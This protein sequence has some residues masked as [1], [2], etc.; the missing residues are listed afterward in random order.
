MSMALSSPSTEVD[1]FFSY[2]HSDERLRD[3]LAKHL[4]LLERQHFIRSWHDRRIGAGDE[5]SHAIDE[6]LHG[7]GIILLLISA[8]F[9]ASDYCFDVEMKA[10]LKMHDKGEAIVIPVILRPVDWH[11]SPFGKLEALPKDGKPVTTFDNQDA[12]YAEIATGI[13]KAIETLSERPV[14]HQPQPKTK[15]ALL[16]VTAS[17][18]L[19]LGLAIDVSGSMQTSIGSERGPD[20]NRLQAVLNS[21]KSIAG[22]SAQSSPEAGLNAISRVV[23][24]FSY[25]FGFTDRAAD[26]GK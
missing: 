23:R 4:K 7:G 18:P 22:A 21:L 20:Q 15:L 6:H 24:I 12:A 13:R 25:G 10:A 26:F 16:P 17:S 1:L 19:V 8:D 2:S 5:W 14:T 11:S 9:L 3:D